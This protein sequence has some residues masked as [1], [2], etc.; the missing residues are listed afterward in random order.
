MPYSSLCTL[1]RYVMWIKSQDCAGS[2]RQVHI[3]FRILSHM[4]LL[5]YYESNIALA[6]QQQNDIT[7]MYRDAI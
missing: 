4:I 1:V 3:Y 5:S 7:Q 6:K 2:V